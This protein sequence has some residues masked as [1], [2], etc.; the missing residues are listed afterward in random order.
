MWDFRL[1]QAIGLMFKTLPFIIFRLVVYFGIALAYVL[2]TGVGAGVGWGV[3]MC[4]V[5][6]FCM[7][8]KQ[9]I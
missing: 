4:C 3:G 1:G 5:S 7:W 9:G 6:T 2:M 8:S